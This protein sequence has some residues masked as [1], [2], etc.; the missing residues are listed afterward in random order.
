MGNYIGTDSSGLK[1]LPNGGAG[2]ALDDVFFNTIGAPDTEGRNLISG[3]MGYGISISD[4]A[5]VNEILGNFIGTNGSGTNA[6]PNGGDGVNLANVSGN[7]IGGTLPADRNV[8][9]GN[10]GSGI[11]L[12]AG[13][14][15][16]LVVGNFI[17][18]DMSGEY[19]LGN[20]DGISINAAIG[21]IIGGIASGAA[22]VISGNTSIGIQISNSLAT[23]NTVL[24]NLIGTDKDGTRVVPS[25]GATPGFPV[26]IL[27]NDSPANMIGGTTAGAGNVISG[28]GVAVNISAFNATANAI[29]G[30]LIGSAQNGEVLTNAN[31]IGIYLNGA[32]G[33]LVGGSTKAAGNTIM[34]YTDYGVYLFGSQS[35][36]NVVQGNQIGQ[37]V[38]P[39]ALAAKHPAQQLA[40]VGI[41]G[42]SSNII[43]G[44]R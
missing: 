42:A 6:L 32:G 10:A 18:T 15:D 24:G 4:S 1:T 11:D 22:N 39:K 9:S 23:D 26:G 21:N 16:N 3:N 2:V 19:P 35:T 5:A 36:G 27:I 14:N 41:Q 29:Q 44:A 31:V 28:F 8:I 38:A 43:G 20:A 13:A 33:N 25:P 37:R 40:G 34:G 30:N 17:G 7:I 12:T